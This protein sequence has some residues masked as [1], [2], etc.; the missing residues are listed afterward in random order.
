MERLS[1]RVIIGLAVLN[2]SMGIA[3]LFVD[4]H[5]FVEVPSYLWPWVPICSLYPFLL[6]VVYVWHFALRRFPNFLLLFTVFGSLGYGIAA[7]FFYAWYMV[8]QGGFQWYEFGNIL[9]VWIYAA[10]G[11]WLS[12]YVH[13]GRWQLVLI[14]LYFLAKDFFDRFSITWSYVR[15]E[16]LS[17]SLMNGIFLFL[18]VVHSGLTF[19]FW[20]YRRAP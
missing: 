9:W 17:D 15:Y 2:L 18:L 13:V 11:L 19:F 4:F 6:A 1:K 20:R 5:D 10:Q 7:P 12:R 3:A 16:A 14:F 8:D